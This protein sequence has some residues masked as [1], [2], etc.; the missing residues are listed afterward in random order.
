MSESDESRPQRCACPGCEQDAIP[1]STLCPLCDEAYFHFGHCPRCRRLLTQL[2]GACP[3]CG[4][5]LSP[6]F[7]REPR[8]EGG[9]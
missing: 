3:K 4:E 1:G 9:P 6:L 8:A 7:A 5:D 2:T